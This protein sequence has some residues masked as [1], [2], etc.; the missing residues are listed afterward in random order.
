MSRT[1]NTLVKLLTR[2]LCMG[3]LAFLLLR[4]GGTTADG[5]LLLGAGTGSEPPISTRQQKGG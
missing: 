4:G 3:M 2:C 1:R 5:T